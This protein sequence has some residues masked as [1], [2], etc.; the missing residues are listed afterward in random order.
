MIWT[1]V[2]PVRADFARLPLQAQYAALQAAVDGEEALEPLLAECAALSDPTPL[3]WLCARPGLLSDHAEL[4]ARQC[5]LWPETSLL[6]VLRALP[7]DPSR[8]WSF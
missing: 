3:A 4:L 8:P 7:G 6:K 2:G 1:E 5:I